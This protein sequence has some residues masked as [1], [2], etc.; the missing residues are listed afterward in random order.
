M[1]VLGTSRDALKDFAWTYLRTIL[2]I[3]GTLIIGGCAVA[4]AVLGAVLGLPVVV[5]VVLVALAAYGGPVVIA[6]IFG[7]FI[8]IG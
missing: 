6:A 5:V 1:W 7:W 4:G 8:G 2:I 3:G